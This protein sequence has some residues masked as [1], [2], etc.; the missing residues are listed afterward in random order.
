MAGGRETAIVAVTASAFEADR[1]KVLSTGADA[2]VRKPF[3]EDELFE[4]IREQLGVAYVYAE[5]EFAEGSSSENEEPAP[6]TRASLEGL[7]EELIDEMRQATTNTDLRRLNELM[8]QVAV[9]DERVAEGLRD[10]ANRYAYEVLLEL[11]RAD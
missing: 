9:Y 8:D 10:L 2:F 1:E 3:K 6:L 5:E 4:R 11:F 7:P